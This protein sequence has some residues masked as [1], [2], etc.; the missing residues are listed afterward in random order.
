[1]NFFKKNEKEL[2]KTIIMK[3]LKYYCKLITK[4]NM[5]TVDLFLNLSD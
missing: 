4:H 3:I 5:Y 1:M 2:Q